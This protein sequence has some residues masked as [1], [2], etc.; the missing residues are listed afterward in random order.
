MIKSRKY[1]FWGLGLLVLGALT[2]CGVVDKKNSGSVYSGLFGRHTKIFTP[3]TPSEASF[4]GEKV[5]LNQWYIREAFDREIMATTF[6][7][8]STIMMFKR[9]NRWFPVIEPILKKNGIPDDFKFLAVAESNLLN[10][11]SPAKAEG[12]WQFLET[13]GRQYGLEINEHVDERYNIE[14]ATEA[15][16]AYFKTSHEKFGNWTLV[17]ASYNRG[18]DGLNRAMESQKVNTYNDLYLTDETSRYVFRIIALKE[19]Y[20]HPVQYGFFLR[21]SDFYPQVPV[22][23]ITTDTPISSLPDF[24]RSLSINYRILRELNPWIQNY[25]LPN[26]LKKTY[27]FK[28]PAGGTSTTATSPGE[29]GS[30]ETFF[31]DTLKINDLH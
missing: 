25:S 18:A 30:T 4:A 13:T 27:T 7:Q 31:H 26:K 23:L 15:A 29:S 16:C 5:P 8:S 22:K 20:A 9:A 11:V 14:K 28:I 6:M 12:Y 3:A 1:L 19:I 21:E 2:V 24:A 17:A 10:V